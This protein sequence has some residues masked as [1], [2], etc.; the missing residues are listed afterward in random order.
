MLK[1]AGLEKKTKKIL[2]VLVKNPLSQTPSY[3]ELEGDLCGYYKRN[4][5]V[6]YSIVYWVYTKAKIV[7]IHAI[8][9]R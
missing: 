9:K 8:L 4:I 7:V 5:N 1:D 2:N 6:N 3:I